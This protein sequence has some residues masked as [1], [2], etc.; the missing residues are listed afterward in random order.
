MIIDPIRI[1]L[2]D[3][4]KLA[5]ESLS[6][7]LGIDARFSIIK[8]CDNGQEAIEQARILCPDV[9]LVDINMHPV[10]GFDVVKNVME[11][12]PDTKIIG[13]SIN[14]H[15][16]YITRMLEFGARG[17]VTKGSSLEEVKLAIEEVYV[18]KQYLSEDV[19]G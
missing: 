13:I 3:D 2:V 6:L 5:R 11:T 15:P 17:F 18:G 14:N 4:H 8:A 1:I 12:N 10:N 7:L 16:L 19:R 9:M